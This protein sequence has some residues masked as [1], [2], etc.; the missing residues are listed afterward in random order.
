MPITSM[1]R[2]NRYVSPNMYCFGG[3]P[4]RLPQPFFLFFIFNNPWFG[5]DQV[6]VLTRLENCFGG[7][8]C[9]CLVCSSV[10]DTEKN[11]IALVFLFCF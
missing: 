9:N 1:Y 5:L 11:L 7:T 2:H 6:D 3:R 4:I 10:G 8:W